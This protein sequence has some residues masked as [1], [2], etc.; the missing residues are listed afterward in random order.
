MLRERIPELPFS[1]IWVAHRMA[2]R[3]PEHSTIHF[4]ILNTLRSWNFFEIPDSVSSASN[5]GGFGIDGDVSSL[6]GASL[7][8]G[9]KL[10]FAV[11]GDLAFFYDLNV[12]GNRHMGNNLRILLVNNG[13]GSEF[14]LS[15]NP[16]SLFGKD[17]DK[18][19]SAGQHFGNQSRT[20]VKHYVQDLGFE[21][22][23]AADKQEFEKVYER[24]L[25]PEITERPMLFEVFTDTADENEALN[26]ISIIE[27]NLKGKAKQFTKQI[28]GDGNIKKIRKIIKK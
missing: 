9:K 6:F 3:I 21:Y 2:H 17:T 19:I 13:K 8:D 22:F 18:Y 24:F 4:G 27:E 10:Y 26:R 1:N 11:V 25:T 16:G 12:I 28:L 14:K 15:G 23:S 20:L 5:V 7:A